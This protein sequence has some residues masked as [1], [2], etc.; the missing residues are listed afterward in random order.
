MSK[1][2]AFLLFNFLGL[3]ITWAA[4]AYGAT[5]ENPYLGVFV[6]LIYIVLHFLFSSNRFRDFK[7]MCLVGLLGVIVDSLIAKLNFISFSE[8]LA[9]N[10]PL[11]AW[12]IVL[13]LVFS[14]MLPYSLYWLRKNLT[15][16]AIAVRS[17]PYFLKMY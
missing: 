9:E 6:G 1:N 17:L 7:V 5:H 10:I 15:V 8:P 2:F 14:L 12:M 13:W 11:P 16:A 3:E 4:C